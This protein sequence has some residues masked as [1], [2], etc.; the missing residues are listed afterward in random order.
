M[1]GGV[2]TADLSA[3]QRWAEGLMASRPPDFVI[4]DDYLR[5][6][7][8]MPRNNYC[9]VYLHDI[10]K[11]DDD[12]AFHDH[13]W[14]N[15][16]VILLGG[17][18]EHTPAG[19]FVRS[20]GDVISR[21]ANSLHRLEIVPGQRAI[22]LFMTS[23]KVRDWGFACDHGWVHWRDF[24]SDTDSSKTGRG[25]GEHGDLTPTTEPGQER[26]T[27]PLPLTEGS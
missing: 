7:W 6:W 4:G 10:R 12:R 9:N 19:R 16:S 26:G 2:F 20:A 1:S 27:I 18:V 17:Y 5:R 8:V 24:T 21:P 22:S 15:T 25:C 14:D 23:Q 13:P 3:M 11:S